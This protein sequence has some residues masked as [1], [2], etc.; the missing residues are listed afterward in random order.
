MSTI[1]KPESHLRVYRTSCIAYREWTI[2]VAAFK[3]PDTRCTNTTLLIFERRVLAVTLVFPLFCTTEEAFYKRSSHLT[4]TV[5][6][7][8]SRSR[9]DT[10]RRSEMRKE[11]RGFAYACRNYEG[12]M[13]R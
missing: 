7:G 2:N 3:T 4:G 6:K 8:L 11:N 1:S 10:A 5:S 13:S 9:I 12:V